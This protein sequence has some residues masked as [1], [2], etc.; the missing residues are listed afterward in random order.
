MGKFTL[1]YLVVGILLFVNGIRVFFMG[2]FI[3]MVIFTT[4]A[5]I[6]FLMTYNSYR[7]KPVKKFDS[8]GEEFKI[9]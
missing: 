3:G 4:I 6:L 1:P 8:I 7:E 5:W 2:D 9:S